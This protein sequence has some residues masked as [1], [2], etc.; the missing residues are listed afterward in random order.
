ML[1]ENEN[2]ETVVIPPEIIFPRSKMNKLQFV[3][4]MQGKNLRRSFSE[5]IYSQKLEM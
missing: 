1:S 2:P 3:I 5:K 4:S